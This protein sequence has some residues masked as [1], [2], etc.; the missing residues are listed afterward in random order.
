MVHVP[1][2]KVC[3]EEVIRGQVAIGD[4]ND[5]VNIENYL[6]KCSNHRVFGRCHT[7]TRNVAIVYYFMNVIYRP[8]QEEWTGNYGTISHLIKEFKIPKKKRQ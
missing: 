6:R 3:D 2:I 7:K 8:P 5:G 1:L 4:V